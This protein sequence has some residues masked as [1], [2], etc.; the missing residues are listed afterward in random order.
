MALLRRRLIRGLGI[1]DL[2]V[3]VEVEEVEIEEREGV[4]R[5]CSV[6][7]TPPL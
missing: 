3:V 2:R 4:G 6:S 7:L 5:R 1:I